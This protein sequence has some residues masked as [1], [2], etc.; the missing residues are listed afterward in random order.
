MN[1]VQEATVR[2]LTTA[3]FETEVLQSSTPVLIDFWAA[4]CMPCKMMSPVLDETARRL[5]GRVK[6]MKVNVDQ[7]PALAEAFG[8]RGIPTI[9]LMLGNQVLDA[10]SG[11]LP[12]DALVKRVEAKLP[13][14]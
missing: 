10:T 6:V 4:W 8:I 5:A 7:E 12:A 14:A 11:Y 2:H 13:A 1:T 3:S 9:T